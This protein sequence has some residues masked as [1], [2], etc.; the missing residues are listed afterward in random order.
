M[1]VILNKIMDHILVDELLAILALL[2]SHPKAVE[3]EMDDLGTVPLIGSMSK[4]SND[5]CVS[6]QYTICTNNK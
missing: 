5:N 6:T 4:R 1:Q 2:S 3:E